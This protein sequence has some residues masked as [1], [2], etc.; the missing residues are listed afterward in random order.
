VRLGFGEKPD[1]IIR[2]IPINNH[3]SL[4]RKGHGH[5]PL[6]NM[7][8]AFVGFS[9]RK[10]DGGDPLWISAFGQGS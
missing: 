1:L 6:Y 3:R 7:S 8:T 9:Q 4:S 5:S 10:T 2:T